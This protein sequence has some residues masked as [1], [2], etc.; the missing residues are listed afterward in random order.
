MKG[1]CFEIAELTEVAGEDN[2]RNG[3]N[4]KSIGNFENL[5][6]YLETRQHFG[7]E[8]QC[9]ETHSQPMKGIYLNM[10]RWTE[11][12]RGITQKN[13]YTAKNNSNCENLITYLDTR[14]NYVL[15]IE[16]IF[17]LIFFR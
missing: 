14:Q 2:S 8:S 17:C 10:F 4:S 12:T 1:V 6:P 16:I 9:F 3:H 15:E 13:G 5:I 7:L 11:V